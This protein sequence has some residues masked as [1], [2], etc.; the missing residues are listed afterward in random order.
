NGELITAWRREKEVYLYEPGKPETR[1][2]TG[3]DVALAA[4]AKGAY[5]AWSSGKA[6]EVMR[7][8]ATTPEHLSDDG[9]FPA[10]LTMPDGAIL[11]A[12]EENGALAT[13]RVE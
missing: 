7:P 8:G 2:A 4:N 9:G 3:Q 11:A 10:L 13:K 1:L 5:V 12:W 6:V